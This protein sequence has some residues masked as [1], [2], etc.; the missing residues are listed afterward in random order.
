MTETVTIAVRVNKETRELLEKEVTAGRFANLTELLRKL[1]NEYA[2]SP[3]GASARVS[4]CKQQEA[5]L[6]QAMSCPLLRFVDLERCAR[7]PFREDKTQGGTE[8]SNANASP[9]DASR[10]DPLD[11]LIEHLSRNRNEEQHR[12]EMG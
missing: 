4:A 2:A 12:R 6:E 1:L 9:E 10:A 8:S 7:C 3:E 11:E 5:D